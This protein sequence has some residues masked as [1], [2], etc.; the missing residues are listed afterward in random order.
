MEYNKSKLLWGLAIGATTGLVLGYLLSEKKMDEMSDDF[1][2]F[3][4]KF[5]SGINDAV[6][7]SMEAINDI[8]HSLQD[9]NNPKG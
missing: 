5:K 2:N 6:D 7:K 1:Q 8:M 3:A 4:D 9:E